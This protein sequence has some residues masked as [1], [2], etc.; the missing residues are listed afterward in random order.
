MDIVLTDEVH[1]KLWG[2]THAVST[3]IAAWG[4][5]SPDE[6]GDMVVDDV[7]LVPQT[8]TST[9]VDFVTDGLPYAVEKAMNDGRINDLRFCWHSHV[10]MGT[11]FSGTD[12]D[13]IRKVRDSGPIP[14]LVNV[15]F[16]KKGEVNGRLDVFGPGLDD[17]LALNHIRGIELDVCRVGTREV[18]DG[19]DSEIKQYVKKRTYNT[20][21]SKDKDTSTWLQSWADP[22]LGKAS[23]S[24]DTDIDPHEMTDSQ[25][26]YE[27]A[28]ARKFDEVGQMWEAVEDTNGWLHWF[29]VNG[30][31]KG[32]CMSDEMCEIAEGILNDKR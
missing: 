14:W 26:K 5:I 12:E 9:E 18:L 28:A 2:Y 1:D 32:N 21:K 3:E 24:W 30:Q 19:I 31:Y 10:N 17:G 29:D 20:N 11:G 25:L 22:D 27:L 23:G 7:F 16:N 8:V 6:H 13:M 15:I 4:Y